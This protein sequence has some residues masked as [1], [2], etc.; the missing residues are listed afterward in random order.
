M[1]VLAGG[2]CRARGVAQE[3]SRGEVLK[4]RIV[5]LIGTRP[6]AIKLAPVVRELAGDPDLEPVVVSTGQHRQLLDQALGVFG[7][8][9]D[10]DLNL[11]QPDQTPLQLASR[12]LV[13]I[14]SALAKIRPGMVLVQGDT[15]TALAGALAAGYL[16]VPVGHVE[17]GLRSYDRR[18]PF[19]EEMNR[20]LITQLA[21]LH[22]A[23]TE[24]NRENL[25]AE[26]TAADSIL[27]TGN[28]VIDALLHVAGTL[29][30]AGRRAPVP[31]LDGRRLILVTL[32]RR[33]SFGAPLEGICYAISR[34][35]AEDESIVVLFPVHPN[36]HVRE[37]VG[38][39]LADRERVHLVEP[40]E[41][42]DFVAAMKSS[43]LILT[44]SGGVQEEAPSLDKPVLVVREATERPEVISAGAALL[45]GREPRAILQETRRLLDD[46]RAYRRMAA[47]FNPHGDG[48]AAKRTVDGIREFL[49]AGR[50]RAKI[51][52]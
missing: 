23:P 48:Q 4:H 42:A 2:L 26:G 9:P 43:Y 30:A 32:H 13:G 50:P 33:E 31:D 18:H 6:E 51:P 46:D 35:A 15:T 41:Y 8:M 11:M 21:S 19:P 29:S 22:F 49:V 36:P 39:W 24:R 28:T 45:V 47:A 20:C 1:L 52:A 3:D 10:L 7:I 5:H 17:A 34:L 27:V 14:G 25:L 38:R 16:G 12:A 40:L 44:D 37:V